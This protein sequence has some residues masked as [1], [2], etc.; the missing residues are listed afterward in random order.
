M[1]FNPFS[2]L[3]SK[4]Y[5]AIAI[6]AVTFAVVQTVRI[7]GFLFIDGY[8]QKLADARETI[9]DMEKAS[10]D[11]TDAQKKLNKGVT[12]K[13]TKIAKDAD[14]APTDI[15][16]RGRAYA[17]SLPAKDYCRKADTPAESGIAASGNAASN[18][19]VILERADYDI[20]VGNTARLVKVKAWSDDMIAEGLAVPVE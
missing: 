4:I 16:D 5:G 11:A 8:V 13:Q 6:A 14:N 2:A 1:M 12:D 3:T 19:A 7:E 9:R 17:D 18:T 20:L 10:K 15:I